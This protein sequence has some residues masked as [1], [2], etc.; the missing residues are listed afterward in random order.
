MGLDLAL[1]KEY[2]HKTTKNTKWYASTVT[3][4]TI[5]LWARQTKT[6]EVHRQRSCCW[7]SENH[8]EE[9]RQ[10]K[11]LHCLENEPTDVSDDEEG[12]VFGDNEQTQ[13]CCYILQARTYMCCLTHILQALTC[14]QSLSTHQIW[15]QLQFETLHM[16]YYIS[17]IET[18]DTTP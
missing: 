3:V 14:R 2:I 9:K 15:T 12:S 5:L 18:P 10:G 13:T 17:M 7:T 1:T 8:R 11:D 16:T 4:R 6:I